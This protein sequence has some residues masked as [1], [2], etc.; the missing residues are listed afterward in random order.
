MKTDYQL[1][2]PFY[3]YSMIHREWR[4]YERS[5]IY[6]HRYAYLYRK[7]KTTQERRWNEAH[8]RYVRGR[9]RR[10]CSAYDDIRTSF[11]TGSCWKR[12]TK[13]RK[14]WDK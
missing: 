5:Y 3:Y 13:Q 12:F 2:E 4:S 14:Q 9:R 1:S 6:E 8:K 10:L 7:P 11:N